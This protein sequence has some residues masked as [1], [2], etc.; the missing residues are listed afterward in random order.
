MTKVTME[1]KILT[2]L[3]DAQAKLC[4]SA[5]L[6]PAGEKNVHSDSSR[7]ALGITENDIHSMFYRIAYAPSDFHISHFRFKE[8][9]RFAAR[10]AVEAAGYKLVR[11]GSRSGRRV[12]K[13][14]IPMCPGMVREALD[15]V[16]NA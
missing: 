9:A 10:R 11:D 14:D 6:L 8:D 12:V 1:G 16:R 3:K 4:Y 2:I 13:I 5:V 15:A 7:F